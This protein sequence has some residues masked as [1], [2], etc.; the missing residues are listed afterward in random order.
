MSLINMSLD[1]LSIRE[2][3]KY[4]SFLD[5]TTEYRFLVKITIPKKYFDFRSFFASNNLVCLV[6]LWL[7]M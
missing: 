4:H 5:G 6:K 1:L 3:Y 2:W 7:L